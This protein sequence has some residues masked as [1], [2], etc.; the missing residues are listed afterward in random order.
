MGN[1]GHVRK[2]S[3]DNGL[4]TVSLAGRSD[5]AC[6][7][8]PRDRGSSQTPHTVPVRQRAR[9]ASILAIPRWYG[10]SSTTAK[11]EVVS[12]G[13]RDLRLFMQLRG[14]A[15]GVVPGDGPVARQA[16]GS[17]GQSGR[18]VERPRTE[19]R[20]PARTSLAR[21]IPQDAPTGQT[22]WVRP[23]PDGV[24]DD[25]VRVRPGSEAHQSMPGSPHPDQN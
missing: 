5:V 20:L 9:F 15:Q 16:V 22:R 12:T 25:V 1:I 6:D 7:R 3:L 11:T 21:A 17:N 8:G 23:I 14:D 4:K 19:T 18:Y 10:D 13:V 24:L 2:D